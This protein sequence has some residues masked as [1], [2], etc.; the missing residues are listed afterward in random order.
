M[1]DARAGGKWL[2]C[3][4]LGSVRFGL[5]SRGT[6]TRAGSSGAWRRKP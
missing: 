4:I 5:V 1:S 2:V 6:L 3:F